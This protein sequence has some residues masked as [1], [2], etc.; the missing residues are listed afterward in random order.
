MV[1]MRPKPSILLRHAGAPALLISN[2][3][4][5][6]YLSNIP[7]EGALIV[8]TKNSYILFADALELEMAES[9]NIP[10]VVVKDFAK[11]ETVCSGIKKCG[12]EA[13]DMT[14]ARI[15]RFKK[16]LKKTAFVA[17]S[18]VVEHFRRTKNEDELK[19]LK[20]AEKM[21]KELLR[22]IPSALRRNVTERMIAWKI[23]Q[24]ARDLGAEGMAFETIVAFGTH[25]SRPHHRPTDKKLQKGNIVQIDLGAKYKGYHGDM[26]RVFFTA[27]PTSEQM[28]V[29]KA[30]EEAKNKA[31]D[32][33]KPGVSVRTL[34][35][36]ARDVLKKY[37]LETYFTH[38]LGHGVGLEIHEGARLS[39][40][41][42]DD[43]L[44]KN[45]VVT[46]EPGVYIP[47]KFGMRLEDMVF[48]E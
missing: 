35:R 5:V 1:Y 10:N 13:N 26:S 12:F 34:D 40:K 11:L 41:A 7:V 43:H 30:L 42:P 48:V 6:R 16:K 33:V 25:T 46:I 24:W 37:G 20:R 38:S 27:T 2:P 9:Y 4:N 32:A 22:R 14:V 47:G 15:A 31:S 21:T 39:Q 45:E 19:K 44:L 8:A 29:Y 3:V 36:I 28:R 23:E 17:T 18:D